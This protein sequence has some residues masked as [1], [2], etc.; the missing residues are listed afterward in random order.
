VTPPDS[1]DRRNGFSRAAVEG[2]ATAALAAQA[3]DARWVKDLVLT[4]T[5]SPQWRTR[6]KAI[7]AMGQSADP[8]FV[9]RMIEIAGEDDGSAKDNAVR[10][11]EREPELGRRLVERLERRKAKVQSWYLDLSMVRQYWGSERF[12][13]HTAPI[14]MLYAL[15]EALAE[16]HRALGKLGVASLL[17][18]RLELVDAHGDLAKLAKLAFVRVEQPADEAHGTASRDR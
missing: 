11:L 13:H 14:N 9:A 6:E 5:W 12:Y 8:M 2:C 7:A 15:R 16:P 17:D 18:L 4:K 10:G 1:A 3:G